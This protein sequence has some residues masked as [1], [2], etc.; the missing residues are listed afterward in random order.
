VVGSS[1]GVDVGGDH[2]GHDLVV[3]DPD[4]TIVFAKPRAKPDDVIG[5]IEAWK[6]VVVAIDSPPR[7]NR[8][9]RS[10]LTERELARLGVHTFPTPSAAGS[11][12]AFFRWMARGIE[13]FEMV[14]NAGYPL[15]TTGRKGR[16]AIEVFPHATAVALAGHL[17]PARARKRE[18]RER[19]LRSAGVRGDLG[20]ADQ[21][22]AALAAL[23]GLLVQ[24]LPRATYLGDPTEG[25]IVLPATSVPSAG[26][27]R[28]PLRAGDQPHLFDACACGCGRAVAPGR[29][30]V[31]GHDAKL[32]SR[33]VGAV[34]EGDAARSEL[35][36]RGWT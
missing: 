9:G 23:T 4:R 7:W 1:L 6:P 32:R 10:R 30:F 12:H 33:L 35:E 5:A 24:E 8:G 28:A 13:L 2:K 15:D 11:E 16:R 18:W 14:A 20:R 31:H 34:R 27:A 29:E 17:P 21:V 36:R 22:D 26:Y 3:L 25:V 19:L